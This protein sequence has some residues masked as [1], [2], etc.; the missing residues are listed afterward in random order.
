M[1]T[2]GASPGK[3]FHNAQG[4]WPSHLSEEDDVG[5]HL[6]GYVKKPGMASVARKPCG[7]WSKE[8]RI[9]ELI[10]GAKFR[11]IAN[12]LRLP[13]KPRTAE[14]ASSAREAMPPAT[15]WCARS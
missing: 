10:T 9:Q 11:Q 2:Q 1:L 6:T 3:Q 14:A 7:C 5:S 12:G 8:E 15:R 13:A 4:V